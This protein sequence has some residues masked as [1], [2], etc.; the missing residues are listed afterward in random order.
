GAKAGASWITTR[1]PLA[2]SMISKSSAG[3]AFQALAGALATI[4]FGV[5][6]A[7]GAA[8]VSKAAAVSNNGN[9]IGSPPLSRRSSG[10][11]SAPLS[12]RHVHRHPDAAG[13]GRTGPRVHHRRQAPGLPDDRLR[14]LRQ[15]AGNAA[16]RR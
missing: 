3:I 9:R 4:S 6:W 7:A 12:T 15:R 10:A 1:P 16:R 14:P 5:I 2:R 13:L 8:A 11:L